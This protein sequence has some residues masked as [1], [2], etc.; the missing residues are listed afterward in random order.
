MFF[1]LLMQN[2]RVALL[3]AKH[4]VNQFAV[5]LQP[6]QQKPQLFACTT[7]LDPLQAHICIVK[8]SC[9]YTRVRMAQFLH[10]Q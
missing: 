5:V 8:S 7:L 1:Q 3:V 2:A 10:C 9:R 6:F 4:E